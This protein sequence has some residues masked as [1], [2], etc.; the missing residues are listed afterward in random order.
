MCWSD[1]KE[2]SCNDH[3]DETRQKE[4]RFIDDDVEALHEM[5]IISVCR[6]YNDKARRHGGQM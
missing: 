1:D 4:G 2:G 5:G 3:K 6:P